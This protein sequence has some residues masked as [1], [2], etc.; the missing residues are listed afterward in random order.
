MK[1]IEELE[2]QLAAVSA[3][4]LHLKLQ[5]AEIEVELLR[6][7]W[8]IEQSGASTSLTA[9]SEKVMRLRERINNLIR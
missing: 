6:L 5:I 3:R 1:T 2:E 7:C 8:L 9:A 4:E